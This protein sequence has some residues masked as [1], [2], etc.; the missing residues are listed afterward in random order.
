[1]CSIGQDRDAIAVGV[2]NN[3]INLAITID[4][5]T[6][7]EIWVITR[8]VIDFGGKGAIAFVFQHRNIVAV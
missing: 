7:D 6:G 3:Q 2:C 4:I 5:S 8:R 1:M